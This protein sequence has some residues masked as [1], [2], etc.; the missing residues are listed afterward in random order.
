MLALTVIHILNVA[1]M[2]LSEVTVT[3]ER[4]LWDHD[5]LFCG[6]IL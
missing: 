6:L 5:V 4:Q 3:R 1:S 2:V